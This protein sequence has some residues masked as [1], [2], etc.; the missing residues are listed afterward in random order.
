MGLFD[1]NKPLTAVELMQKALDDGK[2]RHALVGIEKGG[3]I[4]FTDCQGQT[5]LMLAAFK[6]TPKAI[7]L[8]ELLIQKGANLD[9]QDRNG[10]TALHYCIHN[11]NVAGAVVLLKAGA[12]PA[13]QNKHGHSAEDLFKEKLGGA[14]KTTVMQAIFNARAWH[15]ESAGY[16][17]VTGK[18]TNNKPHVVVKR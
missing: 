16:A 17:V 8:M 7:A 1:D 5:P 11:K 6:A 13:I 12:N 3:D 4:N 14:K 15:A 9:A 18:N 10:D 2:I